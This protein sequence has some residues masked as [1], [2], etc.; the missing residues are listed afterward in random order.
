V[1]ASWRL[2][3]PL[4]PCIP[5]TTLVKSPVRSQCLPSLVAHCVLIWYAMSTQVSRRTKGRRM[6]SLIAPATRQPPSRGVLDAQL[7][8]FLVLQEVVLTD[9]VRVPLATCAV[10]EACSTPPRFGAA[11][12]A[13]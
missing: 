7:H 12:T 6:L 3:G 2:L 1:L 8:V 9:L 13:M 5:A 10:A 4:C 11:G